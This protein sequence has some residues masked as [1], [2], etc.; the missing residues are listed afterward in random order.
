MTRAGGA[1]FRPSVGQNRRGPCRQRLAE[2]SR[3]RQG[4]VG[5]RGRASRQLG[6]ISR[7]LPPTAGPVRSPRRGIDQT[8]KSDLRRF[9]FF[10]GFDQ[11]RTCGKGSLFRL[12]LVGDRQRAAR[13]SLTDVVQQQVV[14]GDVFPRE[15]DHC[16][17]EQDFVIGEGDLQRDVLG[18]LKHAQG[19]PIDPRSLVFDLAAAAQ[20]DDRLLDDRADLLGIERGADEPRGAPGRAVQLAC[21]G[22]GFDVDAG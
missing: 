14:E 6:N 17:F 16:L 2:S 20:I 15:P 8:D 10:V 9:Q 5:F 11:M 4:I 7:T 18:A 21:A 3:H 1:Q 12:A 13:G 19:R 22:R